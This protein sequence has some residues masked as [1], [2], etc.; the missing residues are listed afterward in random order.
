MAWIS[1]AIV[2]IL[3]YLPC[4]LIGWGDQI[5]GEPLS[6]NLS[7][8]RLPFMLPLP[9]AEIPLPGTGVIRL[10]VYS[11]VLWATL[12]LLL[13]LFDRLGILPLS[14]WDAFRNG[15]L[16]AREPRISNQL[17]IWLAGYVVVRV[18]G[19]FVLHIIKALT[20][21]FWAASLAS[22]VA[23]FIFEFADNLLPQPADPKLV[24]LCWFTFV[25]AVG[26]KPAAVLFRWGV[27]QTVFTM[28]LVH[29]FPGEQRQRHRE[30]IRRNLLA[31]KQAKMEKGELIAP[32]I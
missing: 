10:F 25:V 3:F 18:S 31:R 20:E 30:Q 24:V 2:V 27:P 5:M 4:H 22:S 11:V 16:Y 29:G 14:R 12:C 8:L 26:F 19:V 28:T 7:A 21:V 15:L 23:S 13:D 6:L 1:F 9:I 32:T 17:V